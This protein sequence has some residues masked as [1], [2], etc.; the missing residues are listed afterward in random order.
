M[1]WVEG[2]F[3]GVEELLLFAVAGNPAHKVLLPNDTARRH[4]GLQDF[5]TGI[6]E[7]DA[8]VA[9]VVH[10]QTVVGCIVGDAAGHPHT[11]PALVFTNVPPIE[12]HFVPSRFVHLS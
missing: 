9:L 1:L 3:S 6:E 5:R 2:N 7:Q 4:A 11:A 12:T 10:Q 8:D